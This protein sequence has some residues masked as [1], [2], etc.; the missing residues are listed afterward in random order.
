MRVL[1]KMSRVLGSILRDYDHNVIDPEK[2]KIV[3]ENP[4][5]H[6]H[7]YE[8]VGV[9]PSVLNHVL[10][11]NN[12]Y[13]FRIAQQVS[14]SRATGLRIGKQWMPSDLRKIEKKTEADDHWTT[15]EDLKPLNDVCTKWCTSKY[16]PDAFSRVNMVANVIRLYDRLRDV[17]GL[18]F[19]IVFKG[20]VMVRLVLIEFLNNLPLG[21]KAN[22][23]EFLDEQHCL[24]IS[25]LDFEIVPENHASR[26]EYVHKFLFLDFA[27]L[28][29]LQ[30]CMQKEVEERQHTSGGLLS[31]EWDPEEST[32]ELKQY[33][34]EA[35][36]NMDASSPFHKSTID[37]VVIGGVDPYPP[38]GYRTKSGASTPSPRQNVAIFDCDDTKCVMEASSLFRELGV[39]GVKSSSGG[40]MF[41]AT[42][43]TYIGEEEIRKK[44]EGKTRAA[45]WPGLFHLSRI[46]HA[47]IVYYTTKDGK[48]RCDRLGGEMVDLSQSHNINR[49]ALRRHLYKEVPEPYAEYPIVGVDASVAVLRSYTVEGFLYDLMTM[50]FHTEK[51]PW[52]VTK[53]EKRVMRFVAFLFAHTFSPSVQ[54]SSGM[55]RHAMMSFIDQLGRGRYV[56]TGVL[57]LDA[58]LKTEASIHNPQRTKFM[59]TMQSHCRRFY[60]LFATPTRELRLSEQTLLQMNRLLFSSKLKKLTLQQEL[61]VLVLRTDETFLR[62]GLDSFEVVRKFCKDNGFQTTLVDLHYIY[63]WYVLSNVQ[64]LVTG[65]AYQHLLT[66]LTR[67]GVLKSTTI[68]TLKT[69]NPLLEWGMKFLSVNTY[70]KVDRERLYRNMLNSMVKHFASL[71][72]DEYFLNLADSLQEMKGERVRLGAN[73]QSGYLQ[74]SKRLPDE[75]W[76]EGKTI[77]FKSPHKFIQIASEGAYDEA[78]RVYFDLGCPFKTKKERAFLTLLRIGVTLP[79]YVDYS[80]R[81]RSSVWKITPTLS[82]PSYD[83]TSAIQKA[84]KGGSFFHPAIKDILEFVQHARNG[85]KATNRQLKDCVHLSNITRFSRISYISPESIS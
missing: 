72:D 43:N 33:L 61:D 46:K 17:T 2:V 85:E 71:F 53:K 7:V 83:L 55:K 10:S 4:Y 19:N 22:L 76:V 39:S 32:H 41:Y 84:A 73:A 45:F 75:T 82:I 29:W 20:G 63:E 64:H 48:K 69:I 5:D 57:P 37:R 70:G 47:F 36:D 25:D 16:F 54:G 42:L 31:L 23:M 52:E 26:D 59:R 79:E 68:Q 35:V 27:I 60:A 50:L 67:D 40:D 34:Q 8:A 49:D 78:H 21:N 28:L 74:T 15:H 13:L 14:N 65:V 77:N 58:I 81:L 30:H 51:E 3:K 1:F 9:R 56:P 12:Q 62:R 66:A 44:A 11:L 38:K 18:K 6:F 24:S 80:N